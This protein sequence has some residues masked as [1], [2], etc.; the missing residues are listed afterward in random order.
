[1]SHDDVIK[2]KHFPR[3]WPFVRGIHWSS[4]NSPQKGQW[5]GALMFSLLCLWIN[6][7]VNNGETGD[8]RRHRAHHDV[9]EMFRGFNADASV[10]CDATLSIWLHVSHESTRNSW[11]W[12]QLNRKNPDYVQSFGIHCTCTVVNLK[13]AVR[14]DGKYHRTLIFYGLYSTVC[15]DQNMPSSH[16]SSSGNDRVS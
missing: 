5:C 4:V 11:V 3:H 1:M 12:Q 8:L 16:L 7:W 13:A 10:V 6:G 9:T 14:Y 2:W 15:L